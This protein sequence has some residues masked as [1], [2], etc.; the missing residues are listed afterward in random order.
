MLLKNLVLFSRVLVFLSTIF[1]GTIFVV[2]GICLIK[3]KRE[4]EAKQ[5]RDT[6][7]YQKR[8]PMG[9]TQ[10]YSTKEYRRHMWYIRTETQIKFTRLTVGK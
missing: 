3:I 8:P 1:S 10:E 4:H 5:T 7:N 6:K 9:E 2:I